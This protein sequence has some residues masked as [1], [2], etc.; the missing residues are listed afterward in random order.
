MWGGAGG[1]IDGYFNGPIFKAHMKRLKDWY[2]FPQLAQLEL[3]D[4]TAGMDE[5]LKQVPYQDKLQGVLDVINGKNN[6]GFRQQL[7]TADPALMRNAMQEGQNVEAM[8]R[9]EVPEDVQQQLARHAGLQSVLGGFSDGPMAAG[10]TARDLGLTSLDMMGKG[11]GFLKD[12]AAFAHFLTPYNT[13]PMDMFTSAQD[14]LQRDDM[15]TQYNNKLA[16]QQKALDFASNIA[17][18]GGDSGMLTEAVAGYLGKGGGGQQP[19][20]Q[21]QQGQDW[22][23]IIAGLAKAYSGGGGG[24]GG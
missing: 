16:N 1:A 4:P 2:T 10:L 19:A 24:G 3:N 8:L 22:S 23:K 17:T 9:G 7:E 12:E 14:L 20:Q 13:Q 15:V 21:Q 5:W 18:S 6:A 11:S